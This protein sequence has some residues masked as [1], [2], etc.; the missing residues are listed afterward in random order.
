ML[1]C[2]SKL[3]GPLPMEKTLK[4]THREG[5]ERDALFPAYTLPGVSGEQPRRKLQGGR[6]WNRN[7]VRLQ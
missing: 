1:L 3:V 7:G 6:R 5:A 4:K 2:K